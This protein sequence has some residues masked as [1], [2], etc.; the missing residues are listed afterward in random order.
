MLHSQV[1]KNQRN[2]HHIMRSLSG[3]SESHQL[4]FGVKPTLQP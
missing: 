3:A 2:L 4:L 1:L